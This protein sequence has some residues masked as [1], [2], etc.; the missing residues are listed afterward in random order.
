VIKR[1]ISPVVEKRISDMKRD[2]ESYV[3][4]IDMLQKIIELVIEDDYKIDI[5]IVT[6][7]IIIFIFTAT[8]STSAFIT[9]SLHRKYSSSL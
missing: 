6:D 7:Y 2:G 9:N 8:H 3:P 1:K 4:P 5:D